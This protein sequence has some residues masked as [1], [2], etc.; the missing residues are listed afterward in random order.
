MKKYN[1]FYLIIYVNEIINE[2]KYKQFF[3]LLNR[4]TK[5]Y[6]SK[7]FYI[8]LLREKIK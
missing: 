7:K 1:Q 3:S 6:S 5:K 2:E 4:I 8:F